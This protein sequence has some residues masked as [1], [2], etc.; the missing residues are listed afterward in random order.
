MTFLVGK[1]CLLEQDSYA[2]LPPGVCSIP[3][4]A[5]LQVMLNA[6]WSIIVENYL[7]NSGPQG[8]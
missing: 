1:F 6:D 5:A 7:L 8:A 4:Q 2:P 3:L